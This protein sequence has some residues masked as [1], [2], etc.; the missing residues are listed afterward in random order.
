MISRTRKVD[1]KSFINWLGE[2]ICGIKPLKLGQRNILL[3]FLTSFDRKLR[4]FPSKNRKSE[5]MMCTFHRLDITQLRLP[6]KEENCN[7]TRN[8]TSFREQIAS[9]F[10]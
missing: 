8:A 2:N 3:F 9:I 10:L 6:M 1:I 4:G 7:T 5:I